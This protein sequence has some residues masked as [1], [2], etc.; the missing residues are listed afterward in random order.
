MNSR[1]RVGNVRWAKQWW[2]RWWWWFGI[3]IVTP[4]ATTAIAN[5]QLQKKKTEME[6]MQNTIFCRAV[7]GGCLTRNN[8]G[9][10]I[11]ILIL[12]VFVG[13]TISF[14]FFGILLSSLFSQACKSLMMLGF[15]CVSLCMC[16]FFKL[17]GHHVNF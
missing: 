15:L 12:P 8:V 4:K 16:Y 14:I 7:V 2:Q 10:Y 11:S 6:K 9:N 17:N 13:L 3:V 1:T 5:K